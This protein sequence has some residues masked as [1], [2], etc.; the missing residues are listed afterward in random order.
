MSAEE[1]ENATDPQDFTKL[2]P[3][4]REFVKHGASYT[5][6]PKP[7]V[8]LAQ[9]GTY[10]LKVIAFGCQG[11]GE[12][13]QKEVAA[14]LNA[15]VEKNGAPDFIVILGD[16]IYPNGVVHPFDEKFYKQF[17]LVYRHYPRLKSIP[18]LIVP[19]NHDVA[20]EKTPE[21]L[22]KANAGKAVGR[23]ERVRY[24]VH[25][26]YVSNK[27]KL[28]AKTFSEKQKA[29]YF[30]AAKFP[31]KKEHFAAGKPLPLGDKKNGP[32]GWT[33]PNPYS[34]WDIGD[35]VFLCLD[36]NTIARDYYLF[37]KELRKKGESLATAA[38]RYALRNQ[39]AWLYHQTDTLMGKH[40]FIAM[41]HG[42]VTAGKRVCLTKNDA[43]LYLDKTQRDYFESHKVVQY[44]DIVKYVIWETAG[45]REITYKEGTK[46]TVLNAHDHQM[47]YHTGE[48][49]QWV[50]GTGGGDL[51]Q[52][53]SSA[54]HRLQ[55]LHDVQTG[56]AVFHI[57]VA[58]A[59]MIKTSSAT[60]I[61]PTASSSSS[62]SPLSG[63]SLFVPPCS[64]ANIHA[65]S[66]LASAS[67][68]SDSVSPSSSSAGGEVLA[69]GLTTR[70]EIYINT[71]HP[72]ADAS[73]PMYV[74]QLGQRHAY[75]DAG[76]DEA[77]QQY[78]ARVKEGVLDYL[79]YI[80]E[81]EPSTARAFFHV[82][83]KHGTQG[84][85]RAYKILSILQQYHLPRYSDLQS[86]VEAIAS[87]GG[88]SEHSLYNYVKKA[89][90]L[91]AGETVAS[92]LSS[93]KSWQDL[94]RIK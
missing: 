31:L 87:K 77:M 55:P 72:L 66:S 20:K 6:K 39:F 33:M 7:G 67:S 22:A 65:E 75:H 86:M 23:P 83:R 47:M 1:E 12:E 45:F 44:N 70:V 52:F 34:R 59:T 26:T 28:F 46:L 25:R 91:S 37:E 82:P 3:K 50:L 68:S 13:A 42:F 54:L 9:E 27:A 24:Q 36:S 89:Q 73:M 17:E 4:Y 56:F 71:C 2:W 61:S 94:L 16:N 60:D 90:E 14:L 93:R 57:P 5:L 38:E 21:T 18:F 32:S 10:P 11:T 69:S 51:Q 58:L 74:Y 29:K 53:Y 30:N 64:D 92:S 35:T 40:V 63:M 43:W 8:A 88:R 48:F 80:N 41:H 49:N 62:N 84:I 78:I 79:D 15:Y 81:D 85:R 76:A 19:G